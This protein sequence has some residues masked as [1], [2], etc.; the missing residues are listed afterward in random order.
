DKNLLFISYTSRL[1]YGFWKAQNDQLWMFAVDLSKLGSGDP[2]FAPIW[3]PY[4]EQ[5]DVSLTFFWTEVL[6]CQTDPGGACKGCVEGEICVVDA[7]D[8]SCRCEAK[9]IK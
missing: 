5:T 3:L 8:N 7:T 1:P 4:Q 9:A 6:F 2:S